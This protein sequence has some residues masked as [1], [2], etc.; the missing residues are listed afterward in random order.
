MIRCESEGAT[1]AHVVLKGCVAAKLA[2]RWRRSTREFTMHTWRI[3][4]PRSSWLARWAG[5][6]L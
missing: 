6:P 2:V 1:A 4:V 5:L 3:V